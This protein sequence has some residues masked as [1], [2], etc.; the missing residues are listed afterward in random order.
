MIVKSR[1]LY[2]SQR[3]CRKR[4]WKNCCSLTEMQPDCFCL[5]ERKKKKNTK[6][7]PN[8]NRWNHAHPGLK[9]S[10]LL[11]NLLNCWWR[12]CFTYCCSWRSVD[13]F[14]TSKSISISSGLASHM[15]GSSV[16]MICTTRPSFLPGK[17]LMSKLSWCF[18]SYVSGRHFSSASQVFNFFQGFLKFITEQSKSAKLKWKQTLFSCVSPSYPESVFGLLLFCLSVLFWSSFFFLLFTGTSETA[19]RWSGTALSWRRF[20]WTSVS[21]WNAVS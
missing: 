8:C 2:W 20:K 18:S 4:N 19:V 6:K 10:Y 5:G 16:W 15:E 1:I 11:W 7:T 3:N 9:V 14:S 21:A 13:G 17:R 12:Q